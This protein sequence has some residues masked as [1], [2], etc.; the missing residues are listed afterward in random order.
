MS[1]CVCVCVYM[2]SIL[3]STID[4][5]SLCHEKKPIYICI[6]IYDGW[7]ACTSCLHHIH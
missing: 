2:Y 7:L 3:L 6:N 5:V 1:V 4:S